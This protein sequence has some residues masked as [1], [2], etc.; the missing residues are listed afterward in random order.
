MRKHQINPNQGTFY[1]R[2]D[3]CSSKM[4]RGK[5]TRKDQGPITDTENVTT[6]YDVGSWIICWNKRGLKWKNW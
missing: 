3:Q 2:A 4:S 5:T 6:Q 1:K